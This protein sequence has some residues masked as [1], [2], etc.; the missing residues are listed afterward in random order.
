[1]VLP[2]TVVVRTGDVVARVFVSHAGGDGGSAAEVHRWLVD[3]G[4]EVFLDQDVRDGIVIGEEWQ[5]RLHERLR[6]ADA[7]VCVITSAYLAS[8]WCTAEL[9]IAWSRGSR[10]L[11]VLAE[12]GVRHPLLGSSG[13]P[14]PSG[15]PAPRWRSWWP[16]RDRAVVTD[17]IE[18]SSAARAFLY[19]SI[20]RDRYRRGRAVTVLSVLLVLALAAAGFAATRQRAAEQQRKAAEEQQRAATA[21]LLVTQADAARGSDPRTALLLGIAAERI[22]PDAQT[23]ASLVE[24][25]TASRYAGTLA[26]NPVGVG[27]LAFAPGGRMLAAGTGGGAVL[28]D[29]TAPGRARMLGP[30]LP[31]VASSVAFSPDGRTLAAGT[32][33]GTFL[34]DLTDP[35]RPRREAGPLE[36]AG[37]P[38][39]AESVGF[40][41]DGHTLAVGHSDGNMGLYDLTDHARPRSLG[42]PLPLPGI[43]G[44]RQPVAFSA[45]GRRL[46][47]GGLAGGKG[48]VILVTWDVTDPA[49]PRRI[50]EGRL[51]ANGYL[52]SLAFT[53]DLRAMATGDVRLWNLTDPAKPSPRGSGGRED[54]GA[55]FGAFSPD[56]RTLATAN[57]Q[58]GKVIVWDVTDPYEPRRLGSPLV[59][60]RGRLVSLAFSPDGHT[61]ATGD[62]DGTVL[63]WDLTAPAPPSRIGAGD[64]TRASSMAASADGH[65]LVTGGYDATV[66][67]WDVADPARPRQLASPRLASPA[68][69]YS[70][71]VDVAISSAGRL[72]ATTSHDDERV[73]LWDLADPAA[74]RQ[75]GQPITRD[76][77]LDA[78]DAGA[79]LSPDG[80]ILATA[81]DAFTDEAVVLWDLGDPANPRRRGRPIAFG[82][83]R[84]WA[85]NN[86]S[87]MALSPDARILATGSTDET[88]TLW[89]VGDPNQ[90]RQLGQPLPGY[91]PQTKQV[92]FSPDGRTLAS[93]ATDRTVILWD[94]ADPAK[95]SRIGQP[96]PGD[97]GQTRPLAF[98]PDGRT[99]ATGL[100]SSGETTLWDLTDRAQPRRLGQSL[101]YGGGIDAVAFLADGR[102]LATADDYGVALWDLTD[103]HNLQDHAVEHACMRTGHGLSPDEWARYIPGLAY[104]DTCAP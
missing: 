11:P 67:V 93:V 83:T 90:P 27:S 72:L 86:V 42:P 41:P 22:H 21:R 84:G 52:G 51:D 43:A 98:S 55:E 97:N 75:L 95:P 47:A 64:S 45:D 91:G 8:H 28:W 35:T 79:V 50:G 38:W 32:T 46:A 20:R 36:G 15:Q 53:P 10:L 76:R 14:Q 48:D 25:L 7:V 71:Q 81:G 78:G 34:W 69:G 13:P 2:P 31:P 62:R 96:I 6:W 54:Y 102:T 100:V 101:R 5:R 58:D 68:A 12:P 30:P 85:S 24:T 89:D 16:R 87:A 49:H 56:G 17:R 77:D 3:D 88:V 73:I 94:L 26:G 61:L 40:S 4:H 82:S 74:P 33:G 70:G 66:A 29:L 18:L 103:L 37:Y 57:Y 59:G 104:Q 80:R 60:H 63:L 1:L 23:R 92:A 99:L 44:N 9:A 19:A 65:L 39:T